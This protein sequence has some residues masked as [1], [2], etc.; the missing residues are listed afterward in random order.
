[1]TDSDQKLDRLMDPAE[2]AKARSL[3][4]AQLERIDEV[5]L[6]QTAQQWS[7]VAKV[8]AWTMKELASEFPDLPDIFYANRIKYLAAQGTIEAPGNLDRMRFSEIRL[9]QS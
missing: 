5:L 6:A 3:T 9:T 8:I 7:K 4:G 2:E 1:M